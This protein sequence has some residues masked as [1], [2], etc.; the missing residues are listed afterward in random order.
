MKVLLT[1]QNGAVTVTEDAGKI[2][3]NF[4]EVLGGGQS[5]GAVRSSRPCAPAGERHGPHASRLGR[6]ARQDAQGRRRRAGD[7]F[8]AHVPDGP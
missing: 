1:L 8:D 5:A 2:S 3:L 6:W 7:R 4:T